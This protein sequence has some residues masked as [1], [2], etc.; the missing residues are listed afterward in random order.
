MVDSDRIRPGQ[1]DSAGLDS[2]VRSEEVLV[3]GLFNNS[4]NKV[5]FWVEVLDCR[6]SPNKD[7][8]LPSHN[9]PS[10][11]AGSNLLNNSCS[12]YNCSLSPSARF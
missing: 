12:K 1:V 8:H 2:R 3:E 10:A 5:G 9:V 7:P 6:G 11:E 4:S